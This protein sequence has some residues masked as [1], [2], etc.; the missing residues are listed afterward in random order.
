MPIFELWITIGDR[1][2]FSQCHW[3]RLFFKQKS[4]QGNFFRKKNPSPPPTPP[5]PQEYQM[6]RALPSFVWV[7]WSGKELLSDS[8]ENPQLVDEWFIIETPELVNRKEHLSILAGSKSQAQSDTLEA[9]MIHMF[10]YILRKKN[11]ANL[12]FWQTEEGLAGQEVSLRAQ[13]LMLQ[14]RSH[15]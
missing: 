11:T 10:N 13:C 8:T 2:F 1:L 12:E 3:A 14:S 4:E 15:V 6:D 5:R 9:E 7:E